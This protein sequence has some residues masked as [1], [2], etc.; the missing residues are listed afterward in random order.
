VHFTSAQ[1]NPVPSHSRPVARSPL[2]HAIRSFHERL[3]RAAAA[4]GSA[5][6]AWPQLVSHCRAGRRWHRSSQPLTNS[7][8]ALPN[9]ALGGVRLNHPLRA[10]VRALE[11]NS[12]L[13]LRG[14]LEAAATSRAG[15]PSRSR[16]SAESRRRSRPGSGTGWSSPGCEARRHPLALEARRH[17]RGWRTQLPGRIMPKAHGERESRGCARRR[18]A[19]LARPRAFTA[20]RR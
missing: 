5:A 9:A 3:T 20:P 6:R 8:T 1:L 14:P 4:P 16:G 11:P 15:P 12:N 7:A 17:A 18:E 13:R 10:R 19:S 2:A